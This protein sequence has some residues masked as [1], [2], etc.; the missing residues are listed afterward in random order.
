M[1]PTSSVEF[2]GTV[3]STTWNG[4]VIGSLPFFSIFLGLILGVLAAMMI[5][6]G[7]RA[8]VRAITQR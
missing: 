2:W 5:V 3:A 4:F 1:N 8:A 7:F 6:G